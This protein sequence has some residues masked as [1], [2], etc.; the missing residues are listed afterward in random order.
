M[1]SGGW[2]EEGRKWRKCGGEEGKVRGMEK[3]KPWEDS[4]SVL[5]N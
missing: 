4:K 2:I 5:E 1:I 3:V